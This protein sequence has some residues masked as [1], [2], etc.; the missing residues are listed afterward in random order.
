MELLMFCNMTQFFDYSNIILP[1]SFFFLG[2][3]DRVQCFKCFGLLQKWEPANDAFVE[4]RK[5]FPS[6]PFVSSQ[7]FHRSFYARGDQDEEKVE[8]ACLCGMIRRR[9]TKGKIKSSSTGFA[10]FDHKKKP[11]K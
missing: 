1:L 5:H 6:C 7:E 3:G 10:E 2:P 9:R 4:H 8:T 11:S